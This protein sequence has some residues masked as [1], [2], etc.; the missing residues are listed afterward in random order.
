MKLTF[1]QGIVSYPQSGNVQQF[2]QLNSGVVD[3]TTTNG[4]TSI[5]FA[6]KDAD[7]FL[8]EGTDIA[9]AWGPFA[10]TPVWLYWDIDRATGLRTFGHTELEPTHGITPPSSPA[11]DQHWFNTTTSTQFVYQSGIWVEVIRVFAARFDGSTFSF[12]GSNPRLPFA[13]SQVGLNNLSSF[14]GTILFDESGN[15]VTNSSD[16]T[17]YTS[18]TE[19]FNGSTRVTGIRLESDVLTGVLNQVTPAFKVVKFVTGGRLEL[20]NYNDSEESATA[21]TTQSGAPNALVS[22]ISQGIIT[23]EAWAWPTAYL[24]APLYI[25]MNG[26]LVIDD[27]NVTNPATFPQP[28]V[29]VA[30][31]IGE[32]QI[33]FMQGLGGVGPQGPA[34]SVDNL[35]DASSVEKG[36]SL[37]DVDPDISTLPIAVGVNSPL[38]SGAP[39]APLSHVTSTTAHPADDITSTPTTNI[40]ATDVQTAIEQLDTLIQGVQ[41][42]LD[43]KESVLAATDADLGAT[44]NSSGGTAGTGSFSSAPTVVD[45][46]AVTVG[47]RVLVKDQADPIENGIYEIV[48]AGNWQRAEDH[49][50]TPANEVSGGN[51]TFVEQGSVNIS[52]G[53][54]VQGDGTLVLNTDPINWV[55]FAGGFV[56]L[57]HLTNSSAH[58]AVNIDNTPTAGSNFGSPANLASIVATDVQGAVDELLNDKAQKA[59]AYLAAIDLPAANLVEGMV[60]WV[61]ADQTLYVS[62]GSVWQP[63]VQETTSIPYD[64]MFFIGGTMTAADAI[65]GSYIATRA[66]TIPINATGS[67]AFANTVPL[68]NFSY[69][70]Q[71]IP[72]GGGAPTVVGSVDFLAGMGDGTFTFPAQIVLAAGE[73]LQIINPNPTDANVEDVVITLVGS[74]PVA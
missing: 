29:P 34:G 11:N 72:A 19:F 3:L 2:L 31:I 7:Y 12:L 23:N 63:I 62:D 67:R 69:T 56:T 27:P 28:R 64:M 16:G 50:G 37:L 39:F 57:D 54:V 59:P 60:A 71:T 15:P 14:S 42:G 66:I 46:V 65:S 20:A 74:A 48:S 55:K 22:V 43:P 47:D 41:S 45:T 30:R 25:D 68:G 44:Y 26:D 24:G 18:E 53:W 61:N 33:I 17:F 5:T 10:S 1:R 73:Q 36:V 9:G 21:I 4:P 8:S 49:D 40:T 52:T 6:H 13:G 51:F 38:L 58:D 32:R 35:P 70:I